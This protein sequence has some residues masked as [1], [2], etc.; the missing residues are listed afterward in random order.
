MGVGDVH[1]CGQELL[2]LL[3]NL[4]FPLQG[5]RLIFDGDLFDR[6]Q[7]PVVVLETILNHTSESGAPYD[8][9]VREFTQTQRTLP[10]NH[11]P[12]LL[13]HL[14]QTKHCSPRASNVLETQ[15]DQAVI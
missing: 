5:D 9:R 2:N 8:A 12:W 11:G 1:G 7:F 10:P 4:R 3:E 13:R 15:C 14:V 6:G